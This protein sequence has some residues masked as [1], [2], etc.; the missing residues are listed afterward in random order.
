[1]ALKEPGIEVVLF[2][3]GFVSVYVPWTYG[4]CR[5]KPQIIIHSL[6]TT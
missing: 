4:A 6:M 3:D 1:M 5:T 2:S